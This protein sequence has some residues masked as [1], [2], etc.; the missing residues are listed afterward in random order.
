MP[1]LLLTLRMLPL[2]RR[3]AASHAD[4]APLIEPLPPP[5]YFFCYDYCRR[6]AAIL[7]P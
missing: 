7:P 2:P 3:Y 6:V 4:A 5:A 1:P